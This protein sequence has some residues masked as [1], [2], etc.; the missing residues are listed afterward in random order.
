MQVQS[1]FG[2]VGYGHQLDR[3]RRFLE[4]I[5][6]QLTSDVEFQ[7]MAWSFFQHCW[8]IKDWLKHDPLVSED[9]KQAV[10]NAAHASPVLKICRQLC[11]GTKHLSDYPAHH[12]HVNTTI[13]PGSG[14]PSDMDCIIEDGQGGQLSGK[15][16]AQ[17]CVAEWEHI[18]DSEGLATERLS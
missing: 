4:R 8:H 17:K 9:T 3:A 12:S 2:N 13:T 1:K 10:I 14:Q 11:N 15:A 7:D 6:G 18:L 16:L 5:Q